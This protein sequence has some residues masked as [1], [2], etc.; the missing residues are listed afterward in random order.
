M[1]TLQI[2]LGI[3]AACA[4]AGFAQQ[5]P[6]VIE[7][8]HVRYTVSAEGKNLAFVDRSAGVDYLKRDTQ[9]ACA[10]VRCNGVEYPATSAFLAKGR[11]TIEFGKANAKAV[12]RVESRQSYIHLGV[13]SIS[14]DNVESLVFL[15]I[16]LTLRGSDECW[17]WADKFVF[18][19][20]K[21][22]KKPV[23]MEMS[24][25]WHHF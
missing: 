15:N 25:M 6:V 1:K 12:L 20:Q 8:D 3:L 16:P 2:V 21:H 18:E 10:L 9:S 11:L 4:S 22:L 14:G 5:G 24:A 7:N 19:I 13:E 23:G 17:Y